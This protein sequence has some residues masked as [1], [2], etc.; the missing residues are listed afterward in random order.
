MQQCGAFHPRA[1]HFFG[2]GVVPWLIYLPPHPEA[3][4]M[5]FLRYVGPCERG[6]LREVLDNCLLVTRAWPMAHA[7]SSHSV[8][9]RAIPPVC[10]PEQLPD[11]CTTWHMNETGTCTAQGAERGRGRTSCGPAPLVSL[12][13]LSPLL[14]G[15]RL[16][17][18]TLGA[19][20]WPLPLRARA[21][22][23]PQSR[24]QRVAP[25]AVRRR[26]RRGAGPLRGLCGQPRRPRARCRG[27][28]ACWRVRRRR[29]RGRQGSRWPR[30]LRPAGSAASSVLNTAPVLCV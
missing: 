21:R 11:V 17:E 18:H 10:R 16:A 29:G 30:R 13:L 6:L 7:K 5:Y 26:R 14:L 9:A 2:C 22:R 1:R 19:L 25:H 4:C 8:V 3:L 28:P 27:A 24:G 15:Q 20:L 12:P 23:T